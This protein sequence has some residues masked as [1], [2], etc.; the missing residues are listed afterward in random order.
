MG[1]AFSK[2]IFLPLLCLFL[3]GELTTDFHQPPSNNIQCNLSPF[4]ILHLKTTASLISNSSLLQKLDSFASLYLPFKNTM[5]E[6]RS[7]SE[8]SRSYRGSY[9]GLAHMFGSTSPKS[10]MLSSTYEKASSILASGDKKGE[11]THKL[12][13][14]ENDRVHKEA[15]GI[16]GYCNSVPFLHNLGKQ[17]RQPYVQGL[18][19]MSVM[20]AL[21]AQDICFGWVDKEYDVVFYWLTVLVFAILFSE[22]IIHIFLTRDYF[23]SYLFMIDLIGTIILIPEI[24]IYA[25]SDESF[26][27]DDQGSGILSVARAGRVAR[28]SAMLRVGR[29]A[30]VFRV[31]RTARAV[32]CIL[33][34]YGILENRK[35]RKT[36][37]KKRKKYLAKKQAA[38]DAGMIVDVDEPSVNENLNR[39]RERNH[40]R[41]DDTDHETELDR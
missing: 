41:E 12:K 33:L 20:W 22:M 18:T 15:P 27:N 8:S 19:F 25:T 6:D 3:Y 32:Q 35:K 4:S 26:T 16:V 29:I 24:V 7:S 21:F 5:A 37:E 28:T 13:L 34:V 40:D 1:K 14:S 9:R 38:I 23:A 30:K 31:I 36:K 2:P 11:H 10:G 17:V 39:T